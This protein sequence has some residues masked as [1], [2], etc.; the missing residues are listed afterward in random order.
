MGLRFDG[1]YFPEGEL[2]WDQL[3]EKNKEMTMWD[4]VAEMLLMA[5]GKVNDLANGDIPHCL[6]SLISS[7]LLEQSWKEIGQT[8]N[9]AHLSNKNEVL[10]V[11]P[12]RWLADSVAS[13]CMLCNVQFHPI[14]CSR[15]H[16]RFCGG[17]FCSEC[18]KGRSLMPPKFHTTDP[19]RVCDVCS[20]KL[21]TVQPY[22]M[23]RVSRASQ[24]P[25]HDLTDLSTLRSWLNFPWGQSMEY[26][27]YKAANIICGYDK[28]FFFDFSYLVF[29]SKLK[30]NPMSLY[31]IWPQVGRL[32]PEKSIPQAIL[33]QA[34]GF[35]ILSV[36]NIGVI[37]TYNVGT[38][39]VIARRDDGS[40][41]PPCAISSFGVGWGPQVKH[42]LH[43]CIVHPNFFENIFLYI[44]LQLINYT[45]RW[46]ANRLHNCIEKQRGCEDFQWKFTFLG[47]GQSKCCCWYYRPNS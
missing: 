43:I 29:A 28:V 16:C 39:L 34:E 6:T 4:V 45:G 26:E 47:W 22:L 10:N 13:A 27:I 17:I 41:S 33:R 25:T 46:S 2:G 23:N 31:P 12:P 44:N 8:L 7:S 30:C 11:E 36:V 18:S 19:Q 3:I 15:H 35:A 24:L 37:V 32:R 42:T 1:A 14:M 20:V 40:W 9:D 21:F 5:K 38:G